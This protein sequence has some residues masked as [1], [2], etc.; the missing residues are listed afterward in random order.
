M[1]PRAS[2]ISCIASLAAHGERP[3]L[4]VM[5][6]MRDEIALVIPLKWHRK[7]PGVEGSSP[8]DQLA[9]QRRGH[10]RCKIARCGRLAIVKRA[11]F[12]PLAKVRIN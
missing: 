10:T 11:G 6:W 8:T 12:D 2:I 7:F 1:A 5:A 3:A 4:I 9:S